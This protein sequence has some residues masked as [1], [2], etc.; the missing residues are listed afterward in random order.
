MPMKS[1]DVTLQQQ[2][3]ACTLISVGVVQVILD[4]PPVNA[5]DDVAEIIHGIQ[6]NALSAYET[7]YR[8]EP[9]N[10]GSG[11][12][13]DAAY[14]HFAGFLSRERHVVL[15]PPTQE[16][17]V[18]M[19]M[20]QWGT[21]LRECNGDVDSAM[22]QFM[23]LD[24]ATFE[25]IQDS[26]KA[27]GHEIDWSNLETQLKEI[28]KN[29]RA[30][31]APRVSIRDQVS[32]QLHALEKASSSAGITIQIGPHTYSLTKKDAI[33]YFYDS[34]TGRLEYTDKFTEIQEHVLGKV[35]RNATEEVTVSM[36]LS[37]FILR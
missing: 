37:R 30:R 31:P 20:K 21:F 19:V 29:P 17:D 6:E 22:M 28:A 1:V 13:H 12:T 8:K 26:V 27:T 9:G 33:Y 14:T 10:S 23:V 2:T 34:E 7:K 35:N 24:E 4:M 18:T 3:N 11:V 15:K 25:S 5:S 16:L 36:F 32:E